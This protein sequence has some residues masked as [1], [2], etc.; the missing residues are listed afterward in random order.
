MLLALRRWLRV[1]NDAYI[2][3][4]NYIGS[5]CKPLLRARTIV[6]HEVS[7]FPRRATV[8]PRGSATS[9]RGENAHGMETAA[10]QFR[11][12]ETREGSPTRSRR[13]MLSFCREHCVFDAL[14]PLND[15]P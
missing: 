15:A 1:R 2:F 13:K 3:I 10:A 14:R 4:I 12:D 7:F 8:R 11:G 9:N 6:G 5:V